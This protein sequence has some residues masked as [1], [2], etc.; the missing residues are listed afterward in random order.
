MIIYTAE[1]HL[2]AAHVHS[3]KEKRMIVRSLSDRLKS[4]FH[5][6]CAET[7]FQ[8]SHQ[9]ILIGIAAVSERSG[10]A[11]TI[12]HKAIDFTEQTCEAE[13]IQINEAEFSM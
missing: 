6:T 7:G 4:K 5:L 2:Y 8:D 11:R 12:I 9:Q 13:I 3:L 1:I 10:H